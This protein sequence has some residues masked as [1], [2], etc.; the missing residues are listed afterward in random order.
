MRIV[1]IMVNT[2]AKIYITGQARFGLTYQP[3]DGKQ[4]ADRPWSVVLGW[5]NQRQ[6]CFY[7]FNSSS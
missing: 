5:I 2:D 7:E 3:H 6:E 4:I 1:A